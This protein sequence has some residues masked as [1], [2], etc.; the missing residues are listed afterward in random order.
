MILPHRE[1]PGK[2]P[3]PHVHSLFDP[4]NSSLSK[5]PSRF[6][7]SFKSMVAKYGRGEAIDLAF[8]TVKGTRHQI[9]KEQLKPHNQTSVYDVPVTVD[10]IQHVKVALLG[11]I[12]KT[13]EGD[14]ECLAVCF[15]L[16]PPPQV[17]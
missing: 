11:N 6:E 8:A 14:L 15:R 10:N 4:Q 16:L 7:T 13:K 9:Y 17:R 1:Y 2:E 5:L 12:Y 3:T